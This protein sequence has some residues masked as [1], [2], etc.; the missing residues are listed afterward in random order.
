MLASTSANTSAAIRGAHQRSYAPPAAARCHGGAAVPGAVRTRLV[1]VASLAPRRPANRLQGAATCPQRS[2][3]AP[4]AAAG[5]MVQANMFARMSRLIRSIV[6]GAVSSA[7]DPEKL[8]DTVVAE[9]TD[10]LTRM[11][12]AGAQVFA[13]QKQ[14]EM[15]YKSAQQAADDWLRRAELAVTKGADDLAKEALTRRK[16]QQ[17]QADSL[18]TQLDLQQKAVDQLMANTRTLEAKLSEARSKKDTLKARAAS[19]KT[20]AQIAEMVGGLRSANSGN[21]VVAFEKMEAKVMAMEA[22]AESTALL[23][24]P[25]TLEAKF[26][27]LEVGTVEDELAVLKKAAADAGAAAAAS[28]NAAGAAAKRTLRLPEP[29]RPRLVLS[30]L[31]L[32][33]EELRMR[34]Q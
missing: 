16:A 21:A 20:S 23:S 12:Q 19:A 1:A 34:L 22:E 24:A 10:D 27:A 6:E 13:S 26:F 18:R 32:E 2:R 9:M 29:E 14:L 31:D 15:K 4:R 8:L 28:A 33:V 11:R 3:I 5:A 7:E 30:G 17:Q 25:D